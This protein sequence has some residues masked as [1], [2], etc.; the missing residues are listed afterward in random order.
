MRLAALDLGSNSFH[1]LI[2]D[3]DRDGTIEVIDRVKRMPRI[4]DA[5][6][7]SG[8][9]SDAARKRALR[10]LGDLTEMIDQHE[11]EAVLAVATSAVR[12]ARNGAAF[13]AEV[14]A[15]FGFPVRVI[16][17]DEEARLSYRGARARL[18]GEIGRTTL[19]D[20]GADRSRW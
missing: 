4:G 18:G 20:L 9:L 2:A 19:F 1:V 13:V 10:A 8:Q 6:F 5:I 11:P 17:G 3:V 15:R 14:E 12:E 16:S 7:R